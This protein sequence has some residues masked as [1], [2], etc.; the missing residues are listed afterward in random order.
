M[1]TTL[2]LSWKQASGS[3]GT[4]MVLTA[5]KQLAEQEWFM[6]CAT[7]PAIVASKHMPCGNWNVYVP[8]PMAVE[9]EPFSLR[10]KM[11]DLII[12]PA[13]VTNC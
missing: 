1:R 4:G 10:S 13:H 6:R 11:I 8:V 7:F 3:V 9:Y 12:S 2:S 5:E